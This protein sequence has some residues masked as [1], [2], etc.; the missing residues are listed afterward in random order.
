MQLFIGRASLKG[1]LARYK[2]SFNM[3]ELSAER[4]RIPRP[5]RLQRWREEAG[6]DFAF[7]VRVPQS[8]SVLEQSEPEAQDIEFV[9]QVARALDAQWLLIRTPA[10]VTPSSRSRER[11]AA[12]ASRLTALGRPLAWEPRGLWEPAPAAALAERHALTLVSDLSRDAASDLGPGDGGGVVYTRLLALGEQNRLG[13]GSADLL[14]ERL[15]GKGRAYVVIEADAAV[16]F[17]R[18]LREAVHDSGQIE[19]DAPA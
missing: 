17:A 9:D 14:A 15:T 7:S 10:S 19:A 11:L 3:L 2:K 4:G 13:A 16:R 18:L 1:D 5:S 8:M 6:A 12:L